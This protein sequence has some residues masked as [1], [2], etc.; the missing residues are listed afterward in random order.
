MVVVGADFDIVLPAAFALGALGFADLD[1]SIEQCRSRSLASRPLLVSCGYHR[2]VPC[3]TISRSCNRARS[4]ATK[5]PRNWAAGCRRVERQYRLW[6]RGMAD[7]AVAARLFQSLEH[8]AAL[9]EDT[10]PFFR[11]L[12]IGET[13]IGFRNLREKNTRWPTRL[14]PAGSSR[15]P[16]R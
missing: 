3:E 7:D 2:H 4:L 13:L 1:P 8:F 12:G 5:F 11:Q 9:V 10:I 16:R 14:F 6:R 15:F